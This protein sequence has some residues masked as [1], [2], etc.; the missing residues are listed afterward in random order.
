M[1]A[2]GLRFDEVFPEIKGPI[3]K[4]KNS[5]AERNY[6]EESR[7]FFEKGSFVVE[8]KY[9]MGFTVKIPC[10]NLETYFSEKLFDGDLKKGKDAVEILRKYVWL[11]YISGLYPRKSQIFKIIKCAIP[12]SFLYIEKCLEIDPIKF[13]LENLQKELKDKE[14]A[15]R[16][17]LEQ[18]VK[19]N[20]MDKKNRTTEYPTP[21][22]FSYICVQ[23]YF[24]DRRKEEY[25]NPKLWEHHIELFLERKRKSKGNVSGIKSK[26][27]KISTS[28]DSDEEYNPDSPSDVSEG[29]SD[30]YSVAS[31]NC[32]PTG[33]AGTTW[34]GDEPSF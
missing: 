21:R 13:R 22:H 14:N 17:I 2:G 27:V 32:T 10:V 29:E 20:S 18:I 15:I 5:I 12:I 31:E 28:K 4:R 11:E 26:R 23:A 9:P 7:I 19:F 8:R 24:K 6:Y 1:K 3:D 16:T 25:K 33:S 34:A 30:T